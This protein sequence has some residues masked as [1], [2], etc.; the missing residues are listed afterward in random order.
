L[1]FAC[2]PA[3]FL[4]GGMLRGSGDGNPAFCGVFLLMPAQ[5]LCYVIALAQANDDVTARRRAQIII[6]IHA[7]ASL[8]GLLLILGR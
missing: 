2:F 5:Y 8:A 3:S 6:W 7:G 4:F 1:Y